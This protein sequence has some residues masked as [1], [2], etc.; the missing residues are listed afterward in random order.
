MLPGRLPGADKNI[1]Y[2]MNSDKI[3]APLA[4][5]LMGSVI[6]QTVG[7]PPDR[8]TTSSI[9]ARGSARGC[10]AG[11]QRVGVVPT[12]LGRSS[13]EPPLPAKTACAVSWMDASTL[14][15]CSMRVHSSASTFL[16]SL[17]AAP[18]PR[19]Q[20]SM[21]VRVARHARFE[22]HNLIE[23]TKRKSNLLELRTWL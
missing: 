8:G 12:C 22:R 3:A 13:R 2:N 7:A 4:S 14:S 10:R 18:Y 11:G 20:R 6:V 19:P 16:A 5:E 15:P 17:M 9:Y 1:W 21:C 23:E